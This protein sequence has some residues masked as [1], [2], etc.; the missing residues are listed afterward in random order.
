M[1]LYPI[2]TSRLQLLES[3][4][5][6]VRVIDDFE[7]TGIDPRKDG[8]FDLMFKDLKEQS[9]TYNEA[10]K[11]ARASAET[12]TILQLDLIRDQKI[13][14]LRRMISVHQ[15]TDDATQR[16]A[17]QEAK[18]II[19]QYSNIEIANYEAETLGVETLVK[20]LKAAKHD[21]MNLLGLEF[22]VLNLEKANSN[23]KK[24]FTNR[25]AV[26]ISTETFDT[27]LLR[28]SIFETYKDL[29]EY[30]LMMA[31]RKKE[32]FFIDTLKVINYGREYFADILAKRS[33]IGNAQ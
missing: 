31:K 15:F 3:G 20:D 32:P 13:T 24:M 27:K 4:Q 17:Y 33:G 12:E 16:M 10:M 26:V 22:H 29:S 11:Q 25:A 18:A 8:E 7:K 5:F 14:T 2:S 19:R 30:V 21:A 9:L 1:K 6:I 23:F 28:T